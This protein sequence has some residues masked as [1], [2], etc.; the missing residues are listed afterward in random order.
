MVVALAGLTLH[1]S[2]SRESSQ[3]LV[4]HMLDGLLGGW[5]SV[6][7]ARKAAMLAMACSL[8]LELMCWTLRVEWSALIL[9]Y[10]L[11]GVA[12]RRDDHLTVFCSVR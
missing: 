6:C 1:F 2:L 9:A 12:V 5:R 3:T 11:W 10:G 4:S 8:A 7:T